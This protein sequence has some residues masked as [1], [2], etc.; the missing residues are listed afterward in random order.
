MKDRSGKV[1]KGSGNRERVW[2]RGRGL[3]RNKKATL[4]TW[5][6]GEPL[7]NR[8][9]HRARNLLRGRRLPS[10]AF[11]LAAQAGAR[12]SLRAGG[13]DDIVWVKVVR[14]EGVKGV[15]HLPEFAG[16]KGVGEQLGVLLLISEGLAKSR[17]VEWYEV[18]RIASRG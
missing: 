8:R 9:G 6:G 17:I 4:G 16:L 12:S 5:E 18:F 15:P 10:F 3:A 7:F 13:G 14:R 11:A 2:V 1:R